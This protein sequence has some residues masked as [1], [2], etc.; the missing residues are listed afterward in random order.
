MRK[1][2][3]VYNANSGKLNLTMD[4]AHKLLSPDTY[5]CQLC[6]LT[7][8]VFKEREE[9]K[10]FRESSNDELVFLH[11]DEFEKD[12]DPVDD[13]PLIFE[14]KDGQLEPFV[15]PQEMRELT[16]LNALVE[17]LKQRCALL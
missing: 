2:I 3:F 14:D 10:K 12:H 4:I 1:L 11:K 15:E 17:L 6:A 7:H 5:E 9:W 16:D 8:G 13:Y